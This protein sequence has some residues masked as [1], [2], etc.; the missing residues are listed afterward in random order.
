MTSVKNWA[1]WANLYGSQFRFAWFNCTRDVYSLLLVN[2]C[3]FF[4]NLTNKI[5]LRIRKIHSWSPIVVKCQKRNSIFFYLIKIIQNSICKVHIK[6]KWPTGNLYKNYSFEHNTD[7]KRNLWRSLPKRM[8]SWIRPKVF[9]VADI[10]RM[11]IALED[12]NS[13]RLG[14]WT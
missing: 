14:I 3:V 9:A 13:H 1:N 6:K 11:N 2:N 5:K 4:R 7:F 12:L 10:C 8:N